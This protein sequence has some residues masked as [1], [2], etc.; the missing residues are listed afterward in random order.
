MLEILC[1]RVSLP[2]A[3][4]QWYRLLIWQLQSVSDVPILMLRTNDSM[5]QMELVTPF[6]RL[7]RRSE[8]GGGLRYSP[9]QLPWV[10]RLAARVGDI[11]AGAGM[12]IGFDGARLAKLTKT[13]TCSAT[14]LRAQLSWHPTTT[15]YEQLPSML[16]VQSSVAKSRSA[17]QT[18]QF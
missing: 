12:D 7:T 11:A 16:A 14:L 3:I 8:G 18:Q 5:S 17:P 15:F 2:L 1:C 10:W 9:I 13:A 6:Q 4:G